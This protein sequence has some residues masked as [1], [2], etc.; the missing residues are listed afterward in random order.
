VGQLQRPV[1]PLDG[2]V[3]AFAVQQP[4][5]LPRHRGEPLDRL[6][7][8]DVVQPFGERWLPAPSPSTN[9]SPDASA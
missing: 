7:E 6:G 8:L 5:H 9:R 4:A 3:E 1:V 2:G